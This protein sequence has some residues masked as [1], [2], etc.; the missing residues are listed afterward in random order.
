MK[1]MR[2]IV[3]AV[4][5]MTWAGVAAPAAEPPAPAPEAVAAATVEVLGLHVH[6]PLS[7]ELRKQ[8]S[9][10]PEGERRVPPATRVTLLLTVPG[11]NLIDIDP[12]DLRVT[13]LVDDR[14]A[15]LSAGAKMTLRSRD[16]FPA[17]GAIGPDGH[18]ASFEIGIPAPPG[19]G[20]TS[21]KF[22]GTLKVRTGLDEKSVEVKA[23]PMKIGSEIAA[24]AATLRL[25][26][27]GASG[28]RTVMTFALSGAYRSIREVTMFDKDGNAL[29]TNPRSQ[30]AIADRPPEM[31]HFLP[32]GINGVTVRVTYFDKVEAVTVPIEFEAGVGL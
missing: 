14:G 6:R 28:E 15:D 4:V 26:S 5:W 32:A 27:I 17:D 18:H 19:P 20:A 3:A 22:K 10:R 8:F 7:E 16:A 12:G 2:A 1:G 13:S 24:G 23:F 29:S 30:A 25:K 21:L 31:L 9:R 11:R